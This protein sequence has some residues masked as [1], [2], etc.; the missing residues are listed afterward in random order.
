MDEI[1]IHDLETMCIVGIHPHE[2]IEPQ[3]LIV[4]ATLYLDTREAAQSGR[5]GRTVHYAEVAE[6]IAALLRFRRYR[7]LEA[8]ATEL[9]CM[10]L[11]LHVRLERVRLE[12]KK[13]AALSGMAKAASLTI[14][15]DRTLLR[16]SS[17]PVSELP[18]SN[19]SRVTD[20]WSS[21]E[22][23][24]TLQTVASGMPLAVFQPNADA[25]STSNAP[26]AEQ[27]PVDGP[28]RGQYKQLL[29]VVA[30]EVNSGSQTLRAGQALQLDHWD[31]AAHWTNRG[32]SVARVF[33]CTTWC[34]SPVTK[35]EFDKRSLPS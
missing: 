3:V 28:G 9:C 14:E 26:G 8:A 2:R 20:L 30:G 12:V 1:R 32:T 17:D 5:I 18:L 13:P 6:Q 21:Q 4:N 24:L 10:L 7:L 23:S 25:S 22:A 16:A 27:Q 15:R 33:C 34:E 19:A 31:A 29:W 35:R 11:G